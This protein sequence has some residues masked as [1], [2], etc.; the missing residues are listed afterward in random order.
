MQQRQ[1]KSLMEEEVK[2]IISQVLSTLNVAHNRGIAHL[3]LKLD[4]ILID[5]TKKIKI[6]DWGL[7]MIGKLTSC[8][9]IC[10]SKEYAAPEIWNRPSYKT[11]YDATKADVFSLGVVMYAL[12]FGRFPF[13][14]AA[15]QLMRIGKPMSLT[16]DKVNVSDPA[17]E[18]LKGML[19]SNPSTRLSLAQVQSHKWLQFLDDVA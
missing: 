12:L 13:S 18:L 19:D 15:L 11:P 9:K 16:F 7:C 5:S 3:D 1:F 10:G 14:L 8:T 6:I 2:S 4:N 17:K